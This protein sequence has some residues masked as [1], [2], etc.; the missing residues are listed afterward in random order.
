MPTTYYFII[1]FKILYLRLQL[2]VFQLTDKTFRTVCSLLN[3]CENSILELE[4]DKEF[5]V[6]NEEKKQLLDRYFLKENEQT[7]HSVQDN[8]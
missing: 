5:S 7:Y 8:L 1:L 2:T 4:S 3:A 6:R